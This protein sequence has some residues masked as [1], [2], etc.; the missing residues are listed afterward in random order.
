MVEQNNPNPNPSTPT[1]LSKYYMRDS[2]APEPPI[3]AD[4]KAP[5]SASL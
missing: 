2:A 4:P 1:P 5:L 3:Q